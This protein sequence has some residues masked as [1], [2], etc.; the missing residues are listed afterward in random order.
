[1][2]TL[3]SSPTFDS[4]FDG[5]D[6]A[7]TGS[8]CTVTVTSDRTVGATFTRRMLPLVL[9]LSGPASGSVFINGTSECT[10]LPGVSS[11]SCTRMLPVGS[12]AVITARSTSS[13][14]RYVFSLDCAGAPGTAPT[15]SLVMS[16]PR[17]VGIS[18]R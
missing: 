4:A 1:V 6:T 2:L 13:I 7:C 3:T 9:S 5:Y 8:T 18:F 16:G 14:N 10:L 12:T 17:E 15:C 11:T